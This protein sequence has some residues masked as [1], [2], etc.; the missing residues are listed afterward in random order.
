MQSH[1]KS[2]SLTF[3]LHIYF[4]AVQ[5]L[6]GIRLNQNEVFTNYL[7]VELRHNLHTTCVP[8]GM[9]CGVTTCRQFEGNGWGLTNVTEQH[10]RIRTNDSTIL[11]IRVLL[12]ER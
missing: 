10:A 11:V 12:S 8:Y 1:Y 6:P 4:F 5:E 7:V 9:V 2:E 3:F